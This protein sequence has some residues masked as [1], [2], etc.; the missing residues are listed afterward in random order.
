MKAFIVEIEN[1][2]GQLF[3][4]VGALGAAQINIE[5]GAGIGLSDTG[6]FG[7][8]ADDEAGARKALEAAGIL[9]KMVD[10][11]LANVP[12]EAGGLARAAQRLAN[13][14]VNVQ[15]VVPTRMGTDRMGVAFGVNDE[16]AARTALGDLAAD[17]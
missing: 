3:R 7:F 8:V 1:R 14:G 16:A 12:D 10:V 17:S 5:T 4:V 15:F 13:A 2:A 11:V 6:G 9:F